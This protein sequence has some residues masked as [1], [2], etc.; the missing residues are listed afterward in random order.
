MDRSVSS[1]G[2]GTWDIGGGFWHADGSGDEEAVRAMKRGIELGIN[3]IDTAGMYGAG[4]LLRS[5]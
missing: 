2:M 3:L 4:Q 1:L 5:W